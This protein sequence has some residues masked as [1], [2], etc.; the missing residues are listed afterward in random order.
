MLKQ[1]LAIT[2][3]VLGLSSG[4]YALEICTGSK[5][6]TYSEIGRELA[7]VG[8]QMDFDI[9]VVHTKGSVEN[10]R[11]VAKGEDCQAA[12][13]QRDALPYLHRVDRSNAGAVETI[14]T[15]HTE[16]VYAMCNKKIKNLD[17]LRGGKKGAV[18]IGKVGSGSA[19]VPLNVNSWVVLAHWQQQQILTTMLHV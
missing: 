18:A 3:L 1:S 2:A 10:A 11:K 19:T 5:T 4:A 8:N 9:E 6:G 12:I 15:L 16:Y 13:M 7:K 14:G 17:N